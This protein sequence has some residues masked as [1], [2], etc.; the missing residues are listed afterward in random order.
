MIQIFTASSRATRHVVDPCYFTPK[1][2]GE[3]RFR[4]GVDPGSFTPDSGEFHYERTVRLNR[5]MFT[6]VVDP[7]TLS[8]IAHQTNV[9]RTIKR[10]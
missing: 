4:H 1:I 7:K 5:D 9:W 10:T 6:S 8:R 3:R 2:R